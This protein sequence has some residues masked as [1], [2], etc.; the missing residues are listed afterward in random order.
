[1]LNLG[2]LAF[3]IGYVCLALESVP[4]AMGFFGVALWLMSRS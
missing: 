1:M 3:T 4:V 2:L